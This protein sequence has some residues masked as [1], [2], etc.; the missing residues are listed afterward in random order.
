[1]HLAYPL[2]S[3]SWSVDKEHLSCVQ[4]YG[5]IVDTE[6]AY[7][8]SVWIP[9]YCNLNSRVQINDFMIT[10][11]GVT[12]DHHKNLSSLIV[13]HIVVQHQSELH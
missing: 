7:L 3:M 5:N 11:L 9:I 12:C 10:Q 1:M 2:Q 4:L 13:K 8:F 6:C